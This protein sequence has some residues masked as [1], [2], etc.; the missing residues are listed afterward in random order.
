MTDDLTRPTASLG[1]A[2][3]ASRREA[4]AVEA[5]LSRRALRDAERAAQA[6]SARRPRRASSAVTSRPSARPV[7]PRAAAG[8]V[9]VAAPAG[10]V[11]PVA[12]A[13]PLRKRV[14]R[15]TFPPVVMA[16][17]AALL[18]GTSVPPSVL[19]D[20]NAPSANASLAS[21]TFS[22]PVNDQV[23]ETAASAP[24]ETVA[25][26]QVLATASSDDAAAPVA[27]R[28]DWS[29][30]SYAEILRQRY[31]N[32]SFAYSTTGTGA[33]RW[34][35]PYAAPISSG[36]GSRNAPCFGCSSYHQGIDFLLATGTP[37]YAVADGVVSGATQ[38]GGFGNHVYIDHVINGQKVTTLYAH[39]VWDSSPLRVGDTIAAGEFVG[40]VGSTG[41]ST[42]P[43]LHLELHLDGVPVDPF[44][45]LTTNAS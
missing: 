42:A 10:P 21:T 15:K 19:L 25:S 20:A 11:V 5:P 14:A 40:L 26:T 45:W 16:A 27:S 4:R 6:S 3:P 36:F 31:G 32:R 30:T 38:G 44:A 18:I 2:V 13:L 9:V 23:I 12:R 33:V 39:M 28:D 24:A 7:T 43:H 35:F 22:A 29:V 8:P 41:A 17:A 37:I 34:P 1:D